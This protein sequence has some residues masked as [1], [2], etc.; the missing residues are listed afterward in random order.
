[1]GKMQKMVRAAVEQAGLRVELGGVERWEQTLPIGE[2]IG[3][4]GRLGDYLRRTNI[5]NADG[6]ILT[7]VVLQHLG[8]PGEFDGLLNELER[9]RRETRSGRFDPSHTLQRDLEFT[10]FRWKGAHASY[11][12]R[13]DKE[14]YQEFEELQELPPPEVLEEFSLSDRHFQEAKRAALEA[15]GFLDFLRVFRTRSNR[16]IVVVGNDKAQ[17]WGGG[18][19]RMFVVEPLEEYLSNDFAIR[20][21]AVPSH[22][23]MRL[24]VPS[25]FPKD[26][27]RE[28][29]DEMPH[30]VIVDGAGP[31]KASYTTRF[32]RA[33]RGYAN[34]FAVFND[35]R[36]GGRHELYEADTPLPG[37]HFAELRKWDD[38]VMVR[39]EVEGWVEPG[40]TY[41]MALWA[42]E[43]AE[44]TL[45]ADVE[46]DWR[47]ADPTSNQP[48]AVLA[49]PIIYRSDI[50]QPGRY[51][52]PLDDAATKLLSGTRPYYFDSADK[53]IKEQIVLGFGPYGLETRVEGPTTRS[54]I[55]AVQWQITAE[56]AALLSEDSPPF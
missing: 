53:A 16:R 12:T 17:Y 4:V 20:Y 50:V 27:V 10:K 3:R 46:V 39:E 40:P 2:V 18:Y 30:L 19:G 49:N 1:M 43:P 14:L 48:L 24:N 5:F 44:K 22:S 9:L 42:P 51:L 34:W 6:I 56:I 45:L 33:V 31:P 52:G 36:S 54:Y 55:N 8:Q 32:S 29:C 21:D 38:Y 11:G 26:F 47:D 37:D 23:T 35:L 25:A 7:P 41:S 13:P 28:L 15:V